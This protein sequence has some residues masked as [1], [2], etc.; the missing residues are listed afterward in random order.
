MPLTVPAYLLGAIL[1]RDGKFV[2]SQSTSGR[3]A[4]T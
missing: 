4:E 3:Q 2:P 1:R